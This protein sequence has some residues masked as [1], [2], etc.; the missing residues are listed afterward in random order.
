MAA[1]AFDTLKYSKRLKDA[2]V[3]DKQAEA[4]VEALAEALEVNL[5]DLPTKDDLTRET[6]LLRRDLKELETSLKRDMKELESSLKRD[7]KELEGSQKRDIKE[8]EGSQKRDLKELETSLK[9]DLTESESRLKHENELMRLEMR[10]IERRMT[11]KL[12]GLMVVAV[13]AV[14][15]LVKLL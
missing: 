15:T 1:I 7:I 4:E 3:P 9:H 5:K 8:L 6:G 13:G 12:G 14:A 10:D 11:I 2:G